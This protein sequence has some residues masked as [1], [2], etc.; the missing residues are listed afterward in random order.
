MRAAKAAKF[1][2]EH[3]DVEMKVVHSTVNWVKPPSPKRQAI[4][5]TT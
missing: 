1:K 5:S 2:A 3:G 4:D